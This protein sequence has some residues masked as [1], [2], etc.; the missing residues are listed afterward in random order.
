MY[1]GI[2]DKFDNITF[3]V[4]TIPVPV[5]ELGMVFGKVKHGKISE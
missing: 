4:L 1:S 5:F 2:F 3:I